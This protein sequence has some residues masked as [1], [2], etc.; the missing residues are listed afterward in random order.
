MRWASE[1]GFPEYAFAA[2]V[3]SPNFDQAD[4]K[5]AE[6]CGYTPEEVA[7]WRKENKYTWHECKDDPE[8]T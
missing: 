4:E 7:Q 8:P 2:T 1:I 5:L 6:I 3:I